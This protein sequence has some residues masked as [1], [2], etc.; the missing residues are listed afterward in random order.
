MQRKKSQQ[1]LLNWDKVLLSD[2]TTIF[3]GK[4]RKTLQTAFL[5]VLYEMYVT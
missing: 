1:N 5:V 3:L 2:L 4:G